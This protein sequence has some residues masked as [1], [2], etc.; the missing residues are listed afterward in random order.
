MNALP[1]RPSPR[2]FRKEG[3]RWPRFVRN[4]FSLG[5]S[6]LALAD[7]V[8][9][10][11]CKSNGEE[12]RTVGGGLGLPSESS[13]FVLVRLASCSRRKARSRRSFSIPRWVRSSRTRAASLDSST[14]FMRALSWRH[15]RRYAS[16]T[17]GGR[18]GGIAPVRSVRLAF[19]G[20]F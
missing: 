6:A 1:A 16:S 2:L 9:I 13:T 8:R 20:T 11:T 3:L 14:S 10:N 15:F 19:S 5:C 18:G 4:G 12:Q 7:Y 17:E